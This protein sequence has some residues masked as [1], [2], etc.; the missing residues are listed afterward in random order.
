[1]KLWISM[2]LVFLLA[3]CSHAPV[4]TAA[5]SAPTAKA[6]EQALAASGI[7]I[8]GELDAPAGFHGFIGEVRGQLVPVYVTPDGKHVLVGTLFDMQGHDLT[9]PV[10]RKLANASLDATQWEMLAKSTWVP[11]G[12]PKAK[13]VVYVFVDTRCPF[14][15]HFWKASQPWVERGTVQIRNVLVAVIA[16]ESL[17]EAAGILDAADPTKAWQANERDFGKHPNPPSD[18]GSAAARARIEANNA[19]MQKLGFYGTPTII[20]KAADGSIQAMQGM[21]QDPE[22]MR[23]ILGD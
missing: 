8:D 18:A 16:P 20:Y 17:P 19:L 4:P 12:N 2:V 5:A 9:T 6:V 3:A 23:E 7:T 11:E 14:C 1:M 10:V 13:R 21:P 15:H 22:T